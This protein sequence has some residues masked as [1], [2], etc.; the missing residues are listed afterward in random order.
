MFHTFGSEMLKT[1][2]AEDWIFSHGLQKLY[3]HFK[4]QDLSLNTLDDVI[5]PPN[6]HYYVYIGFE[7]KEL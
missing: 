3:L 7:D 5:Y 1:A 4:E 6:R 2:A